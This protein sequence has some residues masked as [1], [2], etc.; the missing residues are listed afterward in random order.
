MTIYTNL[1][2]Q[3]KKEIEKIDKNRKRYS[4]ESIHYIPIGK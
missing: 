3:T 2:E 1:I 4:G